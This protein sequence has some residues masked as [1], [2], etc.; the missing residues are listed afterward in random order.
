MVSRG[1]GRAQE[2]VG[3]RS[4]GRMKAV[5]RQ[6]IGEG[7]V[8]RWCVDALPALSPLSAWAFCFT[9]SPISLT[10]ALP[11]HQKAFPHFTPR[12]HSPGLSQTISSFWKSSLIPQSGLNLA[13]CTQGTPNSSPHAT[14]HIELQFSTFLS[15]P[16]YVHQVQDLASFMLN[17]YCLPS[18]CLLQSRS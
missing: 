11:S 4:T 2:E 14:H 8:R 3:L 15:A 9:S 7:R 13:L 5:S 17:P 18:G 10:P 12:A 16:T 6:K 1:Q